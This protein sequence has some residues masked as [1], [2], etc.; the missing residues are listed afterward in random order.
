SELSYS[1]TGAAQ[2]HQALELYGGSSNIELGGV[3]MVDGARSSRAWRVIGTGR[4]SQNYQTP[5]GPQ[6]NSSFWSFNGEGAFG[7][8]NAT[9]ST[10]FRGAHYGGEFHLLESGGPDPADP[11]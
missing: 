4:F 8:R 6:P 9:G 10:T 3:A 7:I 5:D 1:S 2:R 11:A